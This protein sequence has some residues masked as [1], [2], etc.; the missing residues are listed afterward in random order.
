MVFRNWLDVRP[1][2]DVPI[3]IKQFREALV[4]RP[5]SH[6]DVQ[7]SF[8]YL[9]PAP[10]YVLLTFQSLF[11]LLTSLILEMT[12]MFAYIVALLQVWLVVIAP[13]GGMG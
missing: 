10:L 11:V 7:C 1:T 8:I 2:V 4:A 3:L 6:I 9:V 5:D 12:T 13:S